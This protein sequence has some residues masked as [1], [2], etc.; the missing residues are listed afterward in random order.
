MGQLTPSDGPHLEAAFYRLY[1]DHF[2]RGEKKRRWSLRDDIPWGQCNSSLDPAI[3]DVVETFCMV[4]QFLPDYLAKQLPQVR[5]NKGRAW[6]LAS[7][8]YEESKHALALSDWLV[9]GGHRTE[10][11][12]RD[13]DAS[14]SGREWGLRYDDPLATVVYTMV[15]EVATRVNY[16]NLRRAAGGRCPAL[17][18]VLELVGTDEAAHGHFFRRLVSIYLEDDRAATLERLRLVL[19][20]FAMPA[21]HLLADG[22]RRVAAV[23]ALGIFDERVFL[24]EVMAPLLAQLGLTRADIRGHH[25]HRVS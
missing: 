6:M 19:N 7:W 14:V 9:R 1:R 15:Q 3:A 23:R 20:T 13:T 2:D 4:E 8:G 12:V 18:R 11:Q 16:R 5:A 10:G 24:A 25:P 22:R 21:D 17:D